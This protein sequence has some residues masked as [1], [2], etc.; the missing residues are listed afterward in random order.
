MSFQFSFQVILHPG[1]A[2]SHIEFKRNGL[3]DPRQ[4]LIHFVIDETEVTCPFLEWD[5]PF[6]V[7]KR[8]LDDLFMKSVDSLKVNL[9][10]LVDKICFEYVVST[11]FIDR[12][13]R[14]T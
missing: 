8:T 7:E 12:D 2:L 4:T 13:M 9:T 5:K 10:S 3:Y 6:E 1:L 14:K 11:R